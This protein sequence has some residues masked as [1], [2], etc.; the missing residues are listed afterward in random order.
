MSPRFIACLLWLLASL[1]LIGCSLGPL[2]IHEQPSPHDFETTVATLKEQAVARGWVVAD[3]YDFRASLI[4][5]GQADP[6]PMAVIKI[7]SP[8][9]ASRMFASDQSKY[10]SVMAPCSISVYE[11]SDGNTY[12]ASMNMK[13]MSRLMGKPVGAVLADIAAADEAILA[14]TEV[15]QKPDPRPLLAG[16]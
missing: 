5:H 2:M 14:F 4:K 12:V 8:A 1:G 15:D 9:F 16:D 6:G 7:C 11:K 13:L 3:S 10:A